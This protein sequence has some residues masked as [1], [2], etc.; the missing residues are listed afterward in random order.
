MLNK[1]KILILLCVFAIVV[2]FAISSVSSVEAASK[3]VKIKDSISGTTVKI[4]GGDRIGTFYVSKKG[5]YV[6][7]TLREIGKYYPKSHTITKAKVKISKKVKVRMMS[8]RTGKIKT[9][10][11]TKYRTISSYQE[12]LSFWHR[13]TIPKGWKPIKATVYYTRY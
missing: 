10:T 2:G 1:R 8:E 12:G 6:D 11:Y 4:G 13:A 9:K 7:I 3:T 5:S